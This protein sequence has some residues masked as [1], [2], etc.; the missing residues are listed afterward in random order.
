MVK[1][2]LA[3]DLTFKLQHRNAD[4][5]FLVPIRARVDIVNG[6][7]GFATKQR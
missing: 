7:V 5:V 1:L 2:K 3:D 4:S 6:H